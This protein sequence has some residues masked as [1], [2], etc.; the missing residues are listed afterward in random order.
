MT[1]IFVFSDSA[2]SSFLALYYYAF[3]AAAP[4]STSGGAAATNFD[5]LGTH[6]VSFLVTGQLLNVGAALAYPYAVH[7]F[8][9]WRAEAALRAQV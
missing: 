7:R 2:A 9:L 6:L 1:L 4:A 8:R 3:A 5:A